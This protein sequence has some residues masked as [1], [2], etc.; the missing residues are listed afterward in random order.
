MK[1]IA[2]AITFAAILT[3]GSIGILAQTHPHVTQAPHD[4]SEPPLE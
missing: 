1:T 4:A 2:S 3:G